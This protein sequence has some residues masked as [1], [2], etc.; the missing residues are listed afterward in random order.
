[1]LLIPDS[2]SLHEKRFTNEGVDFVT[3]IF[4]YIGVSTRQVCKRWQALLIYFFHLL[5]ESETL[6]EPEK[7]DILLVDDA[8]FSKSKKYFWA[9]NML[10]EV[11]SD[12]EA[13]ILQLIMFKDTSADSPIFSKFRIPSEELSNERQQT[14]V[15]NAGKLIDELKTIQK[16]FHEQR[17]LART[18][19]DG[20]GNSLNM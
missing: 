5:D 13:V 3:A 12:I 20:V 9:M 18:L 15:A 11:D 6:L 8:R 2:C 7:H 17:E 16:A 10:K 4:H 1:M 14:V 19:R